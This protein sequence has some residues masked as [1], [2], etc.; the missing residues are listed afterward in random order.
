MA[1]KPTA[2]AKARASA[3]AVSRL[4]VPQR[5]TKLVESLPADLKARLPTIEEIAMGFAKERRA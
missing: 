4:G 5:E 2:V 3:Q 1:S